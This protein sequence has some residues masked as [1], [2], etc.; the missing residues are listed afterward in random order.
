MARHR[1]N[2]GSPSV[3]VREFT[4]E[5]VEKG[6]E[7]L[8][9][10][11]DEMKRIEPGRLSYD[12]PS[13]GNLAFN[14]GETIRDVFG[15]NSAEFQRYKVHRQFGNRYVALEAAQL[16]AIFVKCVPG[17]ATMLT[18]LIVRLEEK[19]T[20]LEAEKSRETARPSDAPETCR[21][22]CPTCSAI[23]TAEIV[24]CFKDDIRYHDKELDLWSIDTFQILRCRGC[25]QVYIQRQ[26][27][28]SKDLDYNYDPNTEEFFVEPASP[29]TLW[30][31]PQKRPRPPWVKQLAPAL[32]DLLDEV[33]GALDADLRVL[34][35][36]GTRTALDRAMVEIGADETLSFE[37]KLERLREIGRISVGDKQTFSILI[38][39]GSAA[40]HRAWK[41]NWE[42]L[43][44]LMDGMEN[45]LH[46]AFV[47][48]NAADAINDAIPPRKQSAKKPKHGNES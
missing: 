47:L 25:E 14:I 27:L 33:Y 36:I 16:Q 20:D 46:R 24:A 18:G 1:T 29:V 31:L 41:P 5:T 48:G 21:G 19:R 45:F 12:D 23:R 26:P 40:T 11:A 6:L 39:G 35:A 22:D 15:T 30:P 2:S 37:K 3:E 44:T 4:L 38:E 13:V 10:R 8:R 28:F 43:G 17:M 9:R 34:A 32:R 7:K 42:Q